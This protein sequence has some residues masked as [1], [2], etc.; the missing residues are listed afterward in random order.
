MLGITNKIKTVLAVFLTFV[1]CLTQHHLGAQEKKVLRN[2]DFSSEIKG[3]KRSSL[4]ILMVETPEKEKLATIK[5]TFEQIPIPKKFNDHSL[6]IAPTIPLEKDGK[7]QS[8][9]ITQ[10]L[11]EGQVAKKLVA[12]WFNR[13]EKGAFDLKM[14][15][16]RGLYNASAFDVQIAQQT[17]RGNAMLE[18]AGE[19]LLSNTFVIV[20]DY[21]YTNKEEVMSKGKNLLTGV[22]T[23]LGSRKAMALQNSAT[24]NVAGVL[25]KGYVIKTTSYLYR[26]VWDEE[27]SAKFFGALW[28]TEEYLDSSRVEAFDA[29]EGFKLKYIG[30]Q[31]AW[32]NVQSTKYTQKT[33]AE[34]IERAT[35]KATN[36]A[37][38]RLER[39][40]EAFRTKTP[41]IS[42]DPIAAKI[43]TKE[44]LK[45][46][47]KF[48]VLEQL[49]AEDGTTSYKKVTEITVDAKQI[50][51]NSYL[52]E[53]VPDSDLEHTVFKGSSKKLY[54]G[55]LIRFKKNQNIFK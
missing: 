46:G 51:D 11:E 43:G 10:S 40:F 5:E 22:G 25:A 33:E 12:K 47:D 41:L 19:Q 36:A 52:P 4:L 18:D 21:K 29:S 2:E 48:E 17:L 50:W 30:R 24:A 49:L 34:L 7:D 44:G 8:A 32:S 16:Q 9:L 3:F 13:N 55:M 1:F 20:N 31:D 42:I 28:V 54:P 27:A 45:K 23:I 6:D 38:A 14:I 15:K 53:E 35:I 26:L 37:I 39:K